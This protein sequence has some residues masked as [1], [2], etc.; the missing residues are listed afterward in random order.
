[1]GMAHAVEGRFP[2]LDHRV[3]EFAASLPPHLKMRAL[4]EKYLLKRAANGIVPPAIIRRNK[5]PY[6]A[7][8][9]NCFVHRTRKSPEY[10]SELLSP[11]KLSEFNT[12][13]ASAVT[14]LLAK[15]R[16]E[17]TLG[18]KDSM[19]VIGVLS[20]QLLIDRFIR[21]GPDGRN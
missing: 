6:R 20:T 8:D 7:P 21:T 10:V 1:M 18:V 13:D 15:A 2:F 14:R 5:Q 17:D 4:N 19:S 12:F 3:A 9:A 11:Q 16:S